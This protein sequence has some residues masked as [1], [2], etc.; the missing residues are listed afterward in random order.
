[1]NILLKSAKIVCPEN[2]ELHLKKRDILIKKGIIEKIGASVEAPANIK[3]VEKANLHVSLGWFD[4]SV[5]FGEPGYE[6]RETIGN[7][8]LTAGKSGFTDVVLN[9]NTYPVPDTSSDVVFLKE[10]G[11]GK[12]TKLHPMGT[13]TKNADGIDL[14]ELYDMKNAG[15]VAFY[16]FKRQI[17]NPNLLKIALLYAQNFDGLIYSFPQDGNIKGKGVA[18]E[19]EVS[20]KLGLKGIPALAEEL[21]IARDLFILEYAGGKL[22]I[23]TISTAGSVKLIAEAKK[24]GL[25]VSCS[26][27]IHNLF[28]SDETLVGF[29]TNFKVSPPLRTK[30]DSKALIKGLKNGT[31]DFVTSDHV[32]MDVEHKRV[33]FDNAKNGSLGLESAFG[34]LNTLFDLDETVK[35]L[36]NGRSRYQIES[37][38]L[39]EGAKA[40]LT[41]FNPEGEYVFEA[42]DIRSTSKNSMFVGASLKGKVYGIIHN[43]LTTL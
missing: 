24:K 2:R 11:L 21:Q 34:A 7:G 38:K 26:V 9:P 40:C 18:H 12:A 36:T 25:D 31:I 13:L 37:P 28:F 17:S 5:C 4:S 42:K 41:L 29:D 43:D 3:T 20:T 33:E 39:E 22:H 8:L 19:G 15:A 16:D 6:E 35:L 23:P 30:S 27:A 1:M 14:A 32:P 10:R